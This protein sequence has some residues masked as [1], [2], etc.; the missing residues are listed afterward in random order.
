VALT[1]S[2]PSAAIVPGGVPAPSN[3]LWVVSLPTVTVVL[4]AA[5]CPLSGLPTGV[6]RPPSDLGAL[7]GGIPAPN[8]C[9]SFSVGTSGPNSLG[10]PSGGVSA[11]S[12]CDA[13]KS[14]T[15]APGN[16]RA[17]RGGL[18]VPNNCGAP[19]GGVS[20]SSAGCLDSS[21]SAPSGAATFNG[22]TSAHSKCGCTCTNGASGFL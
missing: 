15:S 4:P 13:S 2:I 12:G 1:I 8:N 18:Y 17:L 3:P 5:V 22:G 20:A 10:T 11:S 21:A 7:R 16:L 6:V 19:S 14:G 9:A